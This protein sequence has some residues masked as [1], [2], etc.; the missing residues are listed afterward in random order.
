MTLRFPSRRLARAAC[1][2]LAVL[3]LAAAA[4]GYGW[5]PTAHRIVNSN[6]VDTL[7]PPIRHFFEA[8]RQFLIEHAN[9]PNEWMK[10][11]IYE[12]KRHYI[13]L[14]KYGIFPYLDLPHVFKDA[15]FKHGTRRINR[16]G[17]LPWHVGEY[18]LRLTNAF[19][20]QNWEDAKLAAAALG[21]YV[22]DTRNPLSTTQ[23][24]DGQLVGQSGLEER[25]GT[26]LIDRYQGFMMFRP[27][28]ASKVDDPTEYAFQSV[29]EAN[30]WV[31]QVLLGDWRARL[32]L[33]RYD[34]E[35]FDRLHA[36]VGVIAA[37]ELNNAAHDAGSYWY[38]AWL[39]AG[40]PPLPGR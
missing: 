26:I 11:D 27:A 4:P 16:D 23:N 28:P 10:K 36:N 17:L 20:T 29:L 21:H 5:G 35:Y 34:E 3:L 9:D 39:N 14:D 13:Y 2:A 32:G 19:K 25:F 40:R 18:S 31:N 37:R 15:T 1:A 38:T 6:A 22:A 7:P 8:N 30:S 33:S 12:R 24:Y